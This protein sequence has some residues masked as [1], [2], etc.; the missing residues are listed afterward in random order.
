MF[1][2][3]LENHPNEYSSTELRKYLSTHGVLV[4]R[5]HELDDDTLYNTMSKIGRVQNFKEQQAPIVAADADNISIIHLHN[6][7]FLGKSRMGWHMDQTYLKTPYL[8]TRSLYCSEVD[9]YNVTEFA[10]INF[11]TDRVLEK[12]PHLAEASA[13]YYIDSAKTISS[14]RPI[15]SYCEHVEKKLL[16][17][18]NRLEFIDGTNSLEFKD[19]CRELL[20]SDEIPKVKVEWKPFDFVIFDN[21]QAPHRR[22]AMSGVCKLKRLT[23][24]FWV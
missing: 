12:W 11:L 9:S 20:N 1:G 2:K 16:R 4:F 24:Y 3:F 15:F 14:Y 7:D 23:S 17:Y 19:F 6:E 22:S 21:N 5:G 8:P 13:N 10:D 18:D